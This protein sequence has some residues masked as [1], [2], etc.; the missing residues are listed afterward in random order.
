LDQVDDRLT[1]IRVG[2]PQNDAF[3]VE[4][5]ELD[6]LAF[7]SAFVALLSLFILLHRFVSHGGLQGL[8]S[9]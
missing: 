4:F 2:T 7:A 5:L 1:V 6:L 3:C 9:V 8:F